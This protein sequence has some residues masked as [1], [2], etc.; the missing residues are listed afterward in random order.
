MAASWKAGIVPVATVNNASSDHIMIAV[1]PI[2]VAVRCDIGVRLRRGRSMAAIHASPTAS[3]MA[4]NP[5]D[6]NARDERGHS[7]S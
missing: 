1:R 6:V 2:R 4:G 7:L 3:N 5:R